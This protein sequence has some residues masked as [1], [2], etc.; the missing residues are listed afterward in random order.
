MRSRRPEVNS[1][2][3]PR[4]RRRWIVAGIVIA[5]LLPGTITAGDA[6]DAVLLQTVLRRMAR[7]ASLFRDSALE[8]ACQEKISWRGAGQPGRATFE[9][10][11]V[12][13]DEKGFQDYRTAPFLGKRR[14]APKEISPDDQGVPWYL[15]S[16]YLWVFVFRDSRQ[17][18]HRYRLAG[19]ER[20]L[21]VQAVK[22]EFEPI[23]PIHAKLN[24][25]YGTAWVDP[26]LGQLLKV[27]AFSPSDYKTKKMWED[28]RSADITDEARA[29]F[30]IITTLFTQER[31][32]LRFPGKV[33]LEHVRYHGQRGVR[34]IK[35]EDDRL[36]EKE[37]SGSRARK[38]TLLRVEQTYRKYQFFSVRTAEEIESYILRSP[39]GTEP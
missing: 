8:F 34:V 15:R 11:F 14:K 21:G 31:N 35:K 2:I 26:E 29:E 9:Y 25:W 28:Y 24:D 39:P 16:A 5:A 30:G 6:E 18:L 19:E 3:A 33:T 10:V 4:S 23:L 7:T 38:I 13:D 20:V 22:I 27:V 32:G 1:V 37:K 12:Y 17:H 36:V